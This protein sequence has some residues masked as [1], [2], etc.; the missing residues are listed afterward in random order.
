MNSKI[1]QQSEL[2]IR[3]ND[4]PKPHSIAQL[5]GKI[6]MYL[7]VWGPI[8]TLA[9]FFIC[10]ILIILILLIF[11]KPLN[12]LTDKFKYSKSTRLTSTNTNSE[13]TSSSNNDLN[14][15]N[16]VEIENNLDSFE[17][18][19]KDNDN[20]TRTS[21]DD[22]IRTKSGLIIR[23][24]PD[25]KYTLNELTVN[26]YEFTSIPNQSKN[27]QLTRSEAFK[28]KDVTNC[29]SSCFTNDNCI[30]FSYNSKDKNCR[31]RKSSD[32]AVS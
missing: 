7:F 26:G 13:M 15:I 32:I 31:L 10:I 12:S 18:M 11:R 16:G 30:A 27:I 24:N 22:K 21:S 9:I 8:Y 6:V 17:Y 23:R 25:I 14:S 28:A 2:I 20:I 29:A 4:C 5:I 1:L 3:L 19:V